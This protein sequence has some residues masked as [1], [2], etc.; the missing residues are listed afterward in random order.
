MK[1]G[2]HIEVRSRFE[3][4]WSRGFVVSEIVNNDGRDRFR[5]K[6]RS[7]GAVLPVLFEGDDVREERRRQ[8]WW[9]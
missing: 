4:R 8:M 1:P 5:V 6:R 3:Q 9:Q 2:T 7:D